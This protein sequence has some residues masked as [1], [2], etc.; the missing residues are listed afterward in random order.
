ME[1]LLLLGL[2]VFNGVF[3]MSE[4]ALVSARKAR[5]T[6][7]AEAGNKG[8]AVAL[9]LGADPT[10]FMSTVQIG[11]TSIGV[12]SGI[13]GES[14]LA[15]PFADWLMTFG[16]PERMSDTSAT[17]CVVVSVTY[18]S[19]V[20]GELVPKRLGQI[21]PETIAVLVS[22]PIQFL[23]LI[24]K[25]FVKLL[26]ASTETVLGLL[27]ADQTAQQAVTQDEIDA[28]LNEGSEAGLIEEHEHAM[29]KNVLRL[30]D[31]LVTSLMIPRSDMVVLDLDD[32][33]EDNL[34]KV[35]NTPFSRFPVCRDGLDNLLGILSA[36]DILQ[37][38]LKGETIDL[39][40]NLQPCVFVPESLT[41]LELLAQMRTSGV[42]MVFL[43]DEYGEVQGL[44]T[45]QDV[46]EVLTGEFTPQDSADAWAIQRADGSWLLDGLI[47]IPELKDRLGLQ[48]VPDEDKH[49]YH[50]L[51]GLVMF[52]LGQMPRT[53]D[54]AVWENWQLEVV[55]M[56][57][58]R[59]DKILAAKI[60]QST[61]ADS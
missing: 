27:G 14:V 18:F 33:V 50:T 7:M 24:S 38:T 40:S 17:V 12:L 60:T 57:G 54:I 9:E 45:L 5:L 32:S 37:K 48:T 13:V 21:S 28:M 11:I 51:S 25:P 31:R 47:P 39:S 52:I 61:D 30:D 29:M 15:E 22:R 56:D 26:S 3:A 55:D 1:V 44:V 16:L 42:A 43:I 36:K 8:A 6:K 10:K 35:S 58:R 41:G 49:S 4:L 34:A 53:G 59:I 20:L 23:A 46:L 2:I 19:I